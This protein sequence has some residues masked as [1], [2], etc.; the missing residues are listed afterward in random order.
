MN[1]L[2]NP[3]AS[4]VASAEAEIYAVVPPEVVRHDNGAV[5]QIVAAY[6]HEVGG[7]TLRVP[8]GRVITEPSIQ[9]KNRPFGLR[10]VSAPTATVTGRA[11]RARVYEEL[12]P[13]LYNG[14]NE[15]EPDKHSP[16]EVARNLRRL[17]G[18]ATGAVLAYLGLEEPRKRSRLPKVVKRLLNTEPNKAP[19]Q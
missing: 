4:P 19:A 15:I 13:V 12:N 6:D 1:T 17:E 9:I 18:E 16:D 10:P 2:P 5:E 8:V 3:G 11:Y 14:S 7:E